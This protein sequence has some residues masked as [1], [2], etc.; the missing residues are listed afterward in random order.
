MLGELCKSVCNGAIKF[1]NSEMLVKAI[2]GAHRDKLA[3]NFLK[4]TGRDFLRATEDSLKLEADLRD[5]WC[6]RLV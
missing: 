2:S 3:K 5:R 1:I 6:A 4:G